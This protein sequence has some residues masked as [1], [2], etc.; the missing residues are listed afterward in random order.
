[1]GGKK[2]FLWFID[3][4][5][6]EVKIK[7]MRLFRIGNRKCLELSNK[8]RPPRK[9]ETKFLHFLLTFFKSQSSKPTKPKERKNRKKTLWPI[10]L[11]KWIENKGNKQ[12]GEMF[13]TDFRMTL[14][15][16]FCCSK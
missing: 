7:R 8:K 14:F 15:L 16:V 3:S 5:K 9:K 13:S 6:P 2:T 1:M 12:I 4:N 10:P 11:F